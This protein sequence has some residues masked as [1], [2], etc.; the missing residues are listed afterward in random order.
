VG[1]AGA[2]TGG[3]RGAADGVG[4][5][6]L[7]AQEGAAA[8]GDATAVD[9]AGDPLPGLLVDVAG[10]RQVKRGFLGRA[11]ESL[12]EHVSGEAVDGRGE[13]QDLSS[14]QAVERDDLAD[15]RGADRQGAGLVEQ[16][17]ARL[18]EG[19]DQAGALDD[20]AVSAMRDTPE[21]SAIGAARMSGHGVATTT[22]A[23]A[24]TGSPLSTH[25]RPA[26][27]GAIGRK[28]PA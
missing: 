17:G 19:L 4:V 13:P 9:R 24:R 28:T 5:V 2:A 27:T 16:D 8:D 15:F 21:T 22:T 10:H 12:A 20:D 7:G 1:L 11:D 25:A 18:A 14:G 26:T 3:K 23:S 6:A